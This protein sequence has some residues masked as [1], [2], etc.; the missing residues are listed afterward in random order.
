M[1]K[2]EHILPN[3]I[4]GGTF[5]AAT[6]SVFVYLSEHPEVCGS[7]VKK[8]GIFGRRYKE[9]FEDGRFKCDFVFKRCKPSASIFME[10]TVGYLEQ[11]FIWL[12]ALNLSLL[13]QNF[14]LF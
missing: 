12:N 9:L 6:T 7:F 4:I 13:H 2:P 5:K 11:G 1:N 3:F 8:P 14:Y 10:A